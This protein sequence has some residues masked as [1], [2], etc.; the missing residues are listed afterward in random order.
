MNSNHLET[1]SVNTIPLDLNLSSDSNVSGSKSCS[2]SSPQEKSEA[3]DI[4]IKRANPG[5]AICNLSA[6]TTLIDPANPVSATQLESMV[7]ETTDSSSRQPRSSNNE[8]SD[9]DFKFLGT[10]GLRG[11][12]YARIVAERAGWKLSGTPGEV[13]ERRVVWYRQRLIHGVERRRV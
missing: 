4:S 1:E 2:L 8:F 3:D 7:T 11:L 6:S 12:E 10:S 9:D 13:I 5:P